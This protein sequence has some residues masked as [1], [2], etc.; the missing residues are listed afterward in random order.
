MEINP[1][2]LTVKENYKLLIGSI[3][4]RPIAFISTQS[5]TGARNLAPFSF[6]TGVTSNPPTIAF[7]PA[8]KEP[9]GIKKDTLTNI[10]ETREFVV[11]VVTEEIAGQMNETATDFPPDV[12]EFQI[13]G[14]TP[15]PSKLVKPPRLAESPINMECVL[16]DIMYIGA[17]SAGGGALVVGKIVMFHIADELISEGRINTELLRPVGRL[18]GQE[19][20][21]LG[22]RFTLERKSFRKG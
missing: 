18:A 15:A 6:F 1:E 22:K 16:H 21:T 17:E 8:R 14:L 5:I 2:E 20:T 10:E 4:P 12:D 19:Y 7:A 11:N 9:A 3:L 13:S